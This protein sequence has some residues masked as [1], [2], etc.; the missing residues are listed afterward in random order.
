MSSDDAVRDSVA[1]AVCRK[2][3]WLS[4][5]ECFAQKDGSGRPCHTTDRCRIAEMTS[6]Q[7]AYVVHDISENSFLRA[8][9]GSGKTE[10][11]GLFAAYSIS[12]WPAQPGGL[13]VLSFTRNAADEIAD[14]VREYTRTST[15]PY[16]H[17]VGTIDSWLHKYVAQPFGWLVTGYQGNDE[18][19]SIRIIGSDCKAGFLN[20]F[21]TRYEYAGTGH[22]RANEYFVDHEDKVPVFSSG[23]FVVDQARSSH[24]FR[25]WELRD[26]VNTKKDF[27]RHGYATYEDMES[28]AYRVITKKER[29]RAVLSRRFPCIVIDECQDLSWIQLQIL[30]SLI[31]AGASVHFVGDLNQAIYSFRKVDPVKVK[32]FAEELS[33]REFRLSRNF[34][35]AQPI[36]DLCN[37]LI[38]SEW[39]VTGN[40]HTDELP[41]CGYVPFERKEMNG[42]GSRFEKYL[43][44][45]GYQ[46]E[47]CAIL[48]RGK[49][50]LAQ[51]RP[52][53]K[54]R[55]ENPTKCLAMAVYLWQSGGRQAVEEALQLIGHFLAT[56]CS[57]SAPGSSL[58]YYCPVTMDSYVRWRILLSRILVEFSS[59]KEI[60]D[61]DQTWRKWAA[62]M[63]SSLWKVVSNV[64]QGAIPVDTTAFSP[65]AP[66]GEADKKV[67]E[68][69]DSSLNA[70][71]SRIPTTTIHQAKGRAFDVV[72]LV[73]A[74]MRGGDGGHWT[75]WIR[76]SPEDDEH[77]RFAYVACSRPRKLLVWAVPS[78]NEEEISLLKGLGLTR[79]AM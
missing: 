41:A 44:E 73:S 27:W 33:F 37:R 11:V 70:P 62:N 12:R 26:L 65:R 4:L 68:T 18:D 6:E 53:S 17:F 79:I 71:S 30:R 69:L 31:W 46:A 42:L 77:A 49:S 55:P 25:K 16:P 14:R 39:T 67:I 60:S 34:R 72:L 5:E 40:D 66:S 24:S 1:E 48:A 22:I 20:Q 9:P 13:V 51:L 19:R 50:T 58:H 35:S 3:P 57:T 32:A 63:R 29:L 54:E 10:V 64:T 36:V 61:L 75:Q 23:N 56:Q 8:C 76:H 47:R 15:V 38:P 7:L 59:T 2:P 74:P 21:S 52:C 43:E 78:P 45:C 28:I